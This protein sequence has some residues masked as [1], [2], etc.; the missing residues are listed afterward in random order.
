MAKRIY[1]EVNDGTLRQITEY[2][3]IL[4]LL[5]TDRNKGKS[6]NTVAQIRITPERILTKEAIIKAVERSPELKAR[7]VKF[8]EPSLWIMGKY[9]IFTTETQYGHG[10]GKKP[11]KEAEDDVIATII[12]E[13]TIEGRQSSGGQRKKAEPEEI[14]VQDV[15]VLSEKVV[16]AFQEPGSQEDP[17]STDKILEES[18]NLSKNQ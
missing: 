9:E 13:K 11:G 17:T 7:N 12:A 15:R 6:H 16:V 5:L 2:G 18:D 10:G 4:F 3:G 1:E 8:N 14:E